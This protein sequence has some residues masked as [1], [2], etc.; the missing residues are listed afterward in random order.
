MTWNNQNGDYQGEVNQ[1]NGD[2]HGY[3]SWTS[4][5]R[6]TRIY[7]NWNENHFVQKFKSTSNDRY[8]EIA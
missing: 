5:D 7:G 2:S 3:G 6:T 1:Q 8:E 4:S